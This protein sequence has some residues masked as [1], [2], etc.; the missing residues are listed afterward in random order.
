MLY[1]VLKACDF[2]E[3]KEFF[4]VEHATKKRINP[5]KSMYLKVVLFNVKRFYLLTTKALYLLSSRLSLFYLR[6][7]IG[8]YLNIV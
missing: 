6:S 7:S 1:F 5:P 8:P 3:I 2:L 4:L